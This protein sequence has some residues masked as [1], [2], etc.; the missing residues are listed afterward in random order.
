MVVPVVDTWEVLPPVQVVGQGGGSAGGR[1]GRP[2]KE[3]PHRWVEKGC[4]IGVRAFAPPPLGDY[5]LARIAASVAERIDPEPI[6]F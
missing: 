3:N 4:G 5:T 1:H 2:G 6:P